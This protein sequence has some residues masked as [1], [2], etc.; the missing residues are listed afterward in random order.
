MM[1]SKILIIRGKDRHTYRLQNG[2]SCLGVKCKTISSFS[3]Y[4]GEFFDIIFLDHTFDEDLIKLN[5]AHLILFD[6][7]DSPDDFFPGKTYHQAK[8]KAKHYAQLV[9]RNQSRPDGLKPIAFP[10]DHYLHGS[11]IA[12]QIPDIETEKIPY[13]VG[14]PTYIN[15]KQINPTRLNKFK[16]YKDTNSFYFEGNDCIYNQ[17]VDWLSDLF[18]NNVP[19]KCHLVFSLTEKAYSENY[20]K[21]RYGNVS[22]FSGPRVSYQE[23]IFHLMKSGISLCPTGHDRISFRVFD[24]MAVGSLI[25]STDTENKKMLYMPDIFIQIADGDSILDLLSKDLS[26]LIKESR[27]NKV[28]MQNLS[29]EVIIKDFLNQL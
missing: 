6:S 12:K 26:S 18:D 16:K 4:D 21:L 14:T 25:I 27:C 15:L 13:F 22:K 28:K 7:E 19:N 11:R 5:C 20:Q 29:P 3:E 23:Q 17:R 8:E 2:F 24:C 9:Y 10:I 1:L